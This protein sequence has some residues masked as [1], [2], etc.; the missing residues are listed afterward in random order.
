MGD[1]YVLPPPS[2]PLQ[3]ALID[4]GSSLRKKFKIKKAFLLA[5]LVPTNVSL[6]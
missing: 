5:S 4:R 3:Q 1:P 2:L 6:P